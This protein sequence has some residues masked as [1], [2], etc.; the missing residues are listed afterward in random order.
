[1][2][3]PTL[4][5]GRLAKVPKV[6]EVR[7][8]TREDLAVLKEKRPQ[9][10]RPKALRETHHRLARLVAAGLR[11]ETIITQT[12]YSY[13]R[14]SQLRNDPAFAELVALYREKVDEAFVSGVDEFYETSTS[15][16]LRAERMIEEHL[17]EADESGEKITLK[18]LMALTADRADRFGYS[19]KVVN[20]NENLDFA[21]M[22]EQIARQSGRSNVIDAK[23][24]FERKEIPPN[25]LVVK[26]NDG[27]TDG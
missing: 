8:L 15:N 13:N 5:R 11:V 4:H 14:I 2:T 12:G 17:D 3:Q 9:Q 10:G 19:K 21:A 22:M 26:G 20:R 27:G 18:T 7:E 1:M 25:Q 6:I 16:M 24:L 23:P